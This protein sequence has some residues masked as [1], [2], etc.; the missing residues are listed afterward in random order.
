MLQSDRE[1]EEQQSRGAAQ[2]TGSDSSVSLV[3]TSGLPYRIQL[4]N[5]NG[6]PS[7]RQASLDDGQLYFAI[8]WATDAGELYEPERIEQPQLHSSVAQAK[9]RQAAGPKP[10]TL[11]ECIDVSV[12][13]CVMQ[14]GSVAGLCAHLCERQ[15]CLCA[16]VPGG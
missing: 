7:G 11:D 2:A 14:G 9:A 10:H 16:G 13:A 8:D 6:S 15:S 3:S 5:P 12:R 4:A 1:T